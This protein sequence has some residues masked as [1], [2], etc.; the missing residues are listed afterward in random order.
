[1]P[2]RIYTDKDADISI[3]QGKT[4]VFIGYG[5]QG[6]AQAL[7]LRDSGVKNIVI[8]NQ[9]DEYKKK[10]VKDGFQVKG[11]KE[12]AALADVL[13]LLIP[14]EVQPKVF[15][16]QVGPH[17]KKG[18]NVV[19]ASGYNVMFNLLNIPNGVDVTMAAP[20]MIGA[21]VRS[22]FLSKQGYPCF[23]SVE[24]DETGTAHN[25]VLSLA[26]GIGATRF[27]AIE[28]SCK[29]E[30]A[31]DLLA[32]QAIFPAILSAFRTAYEVLSEAGYSDEAILTDMYLSGEPAEIME[33]AAQVG[34]LGQMQ[35][36]SR[37]SQ[38]GQLRALL[39][40]D[41]AAQKKQFAKVLHED[42]LSGKFASHWS[43]VTADGEERLNKLKEVI[44]SASVFHAEAKVLAKFN[45]A[46]NN[47][48]H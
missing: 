14:D 39:N 15:N 36:H 3:I 23:V 34:L 43:E 28:S 18:A 1:M 40:D 35:F 19:V 5:N 30:T 29:E 7:N 13:L 9:D 47:N 38:Y 42:I 31:L 21:G 11:I 24:K 26:R 33:R 8:G 25:V 32:E 22:R 4:V 6:E 41:G 37:T 20:R 27:G 46:E 44:G 45:H 16:E 48:L 10:A 2:A 12:A 17:L